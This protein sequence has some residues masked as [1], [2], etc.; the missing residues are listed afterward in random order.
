MFHIMILLPLPMMKVKDY[1]PVCGCCDVLRCAV[2]SSLL[3]ESLLILVRF[4]G[5]GS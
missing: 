1:G 3:R 2:E 4:Y 5:Y